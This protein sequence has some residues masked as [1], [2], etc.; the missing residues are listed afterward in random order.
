M[1]QITFILGLLL[2]P[3]GG[4][5]QDV[6]L[7]ATQI[8]SS[9]LKDKAG[10]E[11]GKGSMQ[12]YSAKITAPLSRLKDNFGR[13]VTWT[14]T[15][16]GTLGVLDN[17]GEA[18]ELNPG[19]LLNA[20]INVAHMRH[21][22]RKW[23]LLASLGAG[24]YAET[25]HI[26]WNS[27]LVNGAVVFAYHWLR[28]LDIGIGG[29]LTNSYGMPMLLPVGYLSWNKTGKYSV[30]V[31]LLGGVKVS[32]AVSLSDSWKLR[33]T[34]MEFD[35]M[36]AVIDYDDA[37]RL[38]SSMS[39]RSYLQMECHFAKKSWLTVGAGGNWLRTASI[40]ERKIGS[41]F[42]HRNDEDRRRSKPSLLLNATVHVGF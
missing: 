40:K 19:Q 39:M 11:Y 25:D 2:L 13:P 9:E 33:L 14:M 17:E 32:G 5:G 36:S 27:V 8:A 24:I 30:D 35:G 31:N 41:L 1:R 10:N 42:E 38:Y 34:A 20:G 23:Y 3:L 22:S 15:V 28:G 12:K 18:K 37:T 7:T 6:E 29:A 26:R 4:Y 21:V 16:K